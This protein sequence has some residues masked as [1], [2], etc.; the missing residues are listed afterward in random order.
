MATMSSTLRVVGWALPVA[1]LASCGGSAGDRRVDGGSTAATGGAGG[2][3]GRDTGVGGAV[4]TNPVSAATSASYEGTYKLDSF[5]VNP[6][7][8][9]V[10]GPA[11]TSAHDATFVMVGAPAARPPYV[12]LA[13]CADASECAARV[14]AIRAGNPV[15]ADYAMF[16]DEEVNANLL[17]AGST[18]PGRYVSGLCTERKW[19]ATEL[20]RT[21]DKVRM[22]TRT[23]PLADLSS[24]TTT[25]TALSSATL[26]Q[27]AQGRPCSALEVIAGTKTGPLP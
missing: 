7:A 1:F 11:E 5:T 16:L 17:R 9:D 19:Y 14:T 3:A 12:G 27:E 15:S 13:A 26:V 4:V 25:C 24:A 20:L 10:E 18:Y 23:I 6:T 8:C 22:E 2:S 21:G